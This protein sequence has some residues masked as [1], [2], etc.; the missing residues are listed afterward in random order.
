MSDLISRVRDLVSFFY[1][2]MA[3]R[4]SGQYHFS[5]CILFTLA[6]FVCEIFKCLTLWSFGLSMAFTRIQHL[7]GDDDD[8]GGDRASLIMIIRELDYV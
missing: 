5:I 4:K 7:D 3:S 1:D 6:F 2:K 8:V